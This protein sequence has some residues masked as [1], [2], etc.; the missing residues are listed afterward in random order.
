M[1]DINRPKLRRRRACADRQ[2]STGSIPTSSENGMV[3]KEPA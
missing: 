2:T 1:A 3:I